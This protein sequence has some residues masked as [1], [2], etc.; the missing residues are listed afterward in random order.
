MIECRSLGELRLLI[1]LENEQSDH[2]FSNIAETG[3]EPVLESQTLSNSTDTL[4]LNR[5][6]LKASMSGWQTLL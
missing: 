2:R 6:L 1:R 4:L 3:K 5:S